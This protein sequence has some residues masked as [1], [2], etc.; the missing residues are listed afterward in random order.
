MDINI[1]LGDDI[2]VNQPDGIAINDY[3]NVVSADSVLSGPQGPKGDPGFSPI[4]N[5]TQTNSGATITITD[6]Q[7][8][9]SATV[10]NGANGISP[11]A[12]I[13]QTASGATITITDAQGQTSAN[14][15]NG[16][17]GDSGENATIE[18]GNV[19]TLPPSSSA[20]VENVGSETNAIL[21]FGIPQGQ[22]G[23]QGPA[24]NDGIS[25]RAY[26][27]QITGGARVVIEDYENTTTANI[28]DG[29][30]GT[31]GTDG[32]SPVA[33]VTPTASGATISI[34]DAQGTTTANITNG[35]DGTDGQDGTSATVTAGTTTTG[36]PG[37]N[38]SVTNSGTSSNAI[39]D[40]V[41]PRGADGQNGTNGQDG[42]SPIAT[43]TQNT[44]SATISIQDSQ[45]TT[46]ATVYD[47]QNGYTPVITATAAVNATTGTPYVNVYKTGTDEYPLF[48]FAFG[49]LKGAA[50]A[51][52]KGF[53]NYSTSETATDLT[54]IDGKTIYQKTI[55]MSSLPNATYQD[56]AHGV[57][58]DYLVNYEG[59][60]TDGNTYLSCNTPSAGSNNNN[61]FR[62]FVTATNIRVTVG[63]D[64]QTWS[65]YV[66]MYYTKP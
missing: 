46:T 24:G 32:F 18:V 2:Q 63:Q 61:A 5:V 44:G 14:I 16:Q 35:I 23:I 28:M 29:T 50:G 9:T 11:S 7:G 54:W 6:E 36:N 8:T 55:Y 17:D 41:I 13:V 25:P 43:V 21:N 57:S 56:Y 60:F 1:S 66:T 12:S 53:S 49:N 64:R 34:T 10:N 42:Y 19:T 37:T 22:Q 39:F 52:G 65:G 4:A 58:F 26:V 51:N 3:N 40:F 47:G 33:T 48:D 38:A 45:G 30:D 27:E 20:T 59:V 62:T 31:D 15:S